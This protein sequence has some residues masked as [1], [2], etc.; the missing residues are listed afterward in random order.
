MT[1]DSPPDKYPKPGTGPS[2]RSRH[3]THDLSRGPAIGLP[4]TPKVGESRDPQGARL[5]IPG[6]VTFT[7]ALVALVFGLI[8]LSRKGWGTAV[9]EGCLIAS[10]VL[11]AVFVA[12]ERRRRTPML[13]LSL[14]R[15][16]AFDGA[17]IV[18]FARSA[19]IFAMFLYLTFRTGTTVVRRPA[20]N[21]VTRIAPDSVS[22]RS[23][24]RAARGRGCSAG[25]GRASAAPEPDEREPGAHQQ[26]P[27]AM[28]TGELAL[29]APARRVSR[30]A[31]EDRPRAAILAKGAVDPRGLI[32]PPL[33]STAIVV[34]PPPSGGHGCAACSPELTCVRTQGGAHAIATA[35]SSGQTHQAIAHLPPQ[36]RATVGE[37]SARELR[38][39]PQR[40]L[41]RGRDPRARGRGRL[42]PVDSIERLR[43]ADRGTAGRTVRRSARAGASV[44]S[45]GRRAAPVP[46]PSYAS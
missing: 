8:E 16:P 12:V 11:I 43:R 46:R 20:R 36:A 10:V 17:S 34:V 19:S 38:R 37:V 6:F 44:S 28:P 14:F 7:A 13:D 21:E 4:V 3:H 42:A 2:N 35:I 25:S 29:D 15:R 24:R 39:R 9:V 30:L 41:P 31:G 18:A 5:D 32:N 1:P 26:P 33:A 23:P 40:D 45:G 27:V 22:R